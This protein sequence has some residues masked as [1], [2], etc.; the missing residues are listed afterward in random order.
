A[1]NPA[2]RIVVFLAARRASEGNGLGFLLFHIEL[3]FVHDV[4][5][6]CVPTLSGSSAGRSHRIARCT[7]GRRFHC[8]KFHACIAPAREPM[9]ERGDD[10]L[11]AAAESAMIAVM[12]HDDVAIRLLQTR[13]ARES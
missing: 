1:D 3:S 5:A 2:N 9:F 13:D 8:N 7:Y 4:P 10:M 11:A 6:P 12:Q